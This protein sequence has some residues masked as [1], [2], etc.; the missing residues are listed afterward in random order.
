MVPFKLS[1]VEVR[2]STRQSGSGQQRLPQALLVGDRW[3][4]L[5]LAKVFYRPKNC[6]LKVGMLK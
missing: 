6:L 3:T 5:P 2:A 4:Q 1:T